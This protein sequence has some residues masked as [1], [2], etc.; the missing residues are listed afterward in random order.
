[1]DRPT[2][3]VNAAKLAEYQTGKVVR[4]IGKV[5]SLETEQALL[6][7]ADGGQVVVKLMKATPRKDSNLSDTFVEVIGKKGS[8]DGVVTELSSQNLGESIDLELANKVVELTHAYP[9]VFPTG[10]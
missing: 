3:R 2:P 5:L 1:M 10:E 9:D 8:D 4:V 7:A 6:E